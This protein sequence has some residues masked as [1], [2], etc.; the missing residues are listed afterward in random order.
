MIVLIYRKLWPKINFILHSFLKYYKDFADLFFC[1]VGADLLM[2]T[3]F[4]V[5]LHAKNQLHLS[6]RFRDAT[7]IS[8][9][10]YYWYFGYLHAKNH[11]YLSYLSWNITKILQTCHL[12]YF[13]HEWSRPPKAIALRCRKFW[14]LSAHKK[15]AIM[16]AQF[17]LQI[18]L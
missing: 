15:S 14:Y 2:P 7:K 17:S 5:Y 18:L 12:G 8:Q 3:K 16:I 1:V 11:I 9:N 13:E 6:I 10:C 4:D